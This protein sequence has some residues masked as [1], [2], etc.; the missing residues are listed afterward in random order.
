MIRISSSVHAMLFVAAGL[1]CSSCDT[2]RLPKVV[3]SRQP[4]FHIRLCV[5]G[6]A[7]VADA[8][9]QFGEHRTVGG[10][11]RGN[12]AVTHLFFEHP[13][14]Q[15]AKVHYR[16]MDGVE[17]IRVVPLPSSVLKADPSSTWSLVFQINVAAGTVSLTPSVR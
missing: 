15:S 9:V 14:G 13:L 11:L 10:G 2:T 6:D 1:I 7:E 5:E 4:T 16:T 3:S 8:F 12:G 17:H